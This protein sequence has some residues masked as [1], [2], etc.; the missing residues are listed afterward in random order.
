MAMKAATRKMPTRAA[1]SEARERVLS[2]A[3]DLFSRQG[4]KAVGI[5]TII[6]QAGVAKMTFYKYFPS[7]DHLILAF[8]DRRERIWTHEWLEAAVKERSRTPTGRLLA[9]FDVLG[10][11]F[12]LEDFESCSFIRTM[13]EESEPGPV[14]DAAR[15]HLGDITALVRR[16][17]VEAGLR[18]PDDVAH[19]WQMLMAGSIV[20]AGYGDPSAAKR[21]RAMGEL[22]LATSGMEDV[23]GAVRTKGGRA[24]NAH[25]RYRELLKRRHRA[26]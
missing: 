26:T 1:S 7:K 25:E 10:E 22:V 21:A 23:I 20:A 13:L 4:T 8:L 3:Y 15:A 5:D 2:A 12:A 16:L 14:L 11:W 18:R 6:A 19:K 9:I 24:A 17:V